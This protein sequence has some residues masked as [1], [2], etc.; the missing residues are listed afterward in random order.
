MCVFTRIAHHTVARQRAPALALAP[1]RPPLHLPRAPRPRPPFR[2]S[3]LG[4]HHLPAIPTGTGV[5]VA[6]LAGAIASPGPLPLQLCGGQATLDGNLCPDRCFRLRLTCHGP[7]LV[8]REPILRLLAEVIDQVLDLNLYWLPEEHAGHRPLLYSIGLDPDLVHTLAASVWDYAKGCQWST[9]GPHK[10]TS[11][12]HVDVLHAGEAER[13]RGV[14]HATDMFAT[15]V[16][17]R[18]QPK[19]SDPRYDRRPFLDR[20]VQ[21]IQGRYKEAPYHLVYLNGLTM[22]KEYLGRRVDGV[23]QM[24][25]YLGQE[26]NGQCAHLEDFV[27]GRSVR[28]PIL[29]LAAINLVAASAV[30]EAKVWYCA[31]KDA[32]QGKCVLVHMNQRNNG[33]PFYVQHRD[34]MVPWGAFEEA[35]L[36]REGDLIV[37]PMWCIHQVSNLCQSIAVSQNVYPLP[38]AYVPPSEPFFEPYSFQCTCGHSCIAIDEAVHQMA[39]SLGISGDPRKPR[40]RSSNANKGVGRY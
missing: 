37:Q 13:A 31:D 5:A 24:L 40:A 11:D 8:S 21:E 12:I 39:A 18:P 38:E 6:T 10:T 22:V 23:N 32:A 26:G 35:I 4:A 20:R 27:R 34:G 33:C 36:Q 16:P 28:D 1:P 17:P 2:G 7:R 15:L 3:H 19:T 30:A 9:S 25:A 29:N 14:Q